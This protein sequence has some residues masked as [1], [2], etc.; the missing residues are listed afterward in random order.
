MPR[1]DIYNVD[2]LEYLK[3]MP[4]KAFDIALA[5]PPYYDGPNRRGYYG[6][7]DGGLLG[8]RKDYRKTH[9]KVPGR[10]YFDELRR[11]CRHYIVWGCNYYDYV[12]AP[13][14]IVWD[15][16]N[17]HTTFSDCEIAATDLFDSVRLFRYMWNGMQQGRSVDE[18]WV[19]QGDKRRNEARIHP[20]QKP[21]ALYQWLLKNFCRQGWTVLDTHLGSGS[22][23]IAAYAMGYDFTGCEID[24]EYC[25]L[26]DERFEHECLGVDYTRSGK[27]VIQL[28]LFAATDTRSVI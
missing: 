26:C 24:A 21:V 2:C 28:D 23:R 1:S 12:F 18:G 11:V 7:A 5:D 27:K 20:T 19:Q 9:W 14:R 25:R 8:R 16:C 6:N 15:K 3:G 17:Q 4:D 13:G 10:E 22:S